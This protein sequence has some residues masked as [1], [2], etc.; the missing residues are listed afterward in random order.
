MRKISALFGVDKEEEKKSTTKLHT[1]VPNVR[2]DFRSSSSLNS[3]S[4]TLENTAKTVL[5]TNSTEPFNLGHD[6]PRSK[7][8]R[9]CSTNSLEPKSV[10]I[11]SPLDNKLSISS[12][13]PEIQCQKELFPAAVSI[14]EELE[15]VKQMFRDT[16]KTKELITKMLP[17]DVATQL[18]S[19]T[20]VAT[21]EYENVTI[22]FSDIIGFTTLVSELKP[23][24]VLSHIHK[25]VI[26]EDGSQFK[27]VS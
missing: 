20:S 8:S 22:Y 10:V 2:L 26:R 13:P 15:K 6:V 9:V 24:Q 12:L 1:L 27:L 19:G 16:K 25:Y 11:K 3:K 18:K 4:E 23:K 21:K 7:K 14:A 5:G 17:K